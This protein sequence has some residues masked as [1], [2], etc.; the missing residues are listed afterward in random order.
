MR[1]PSAGRARGA[2]L[3]ARE[4]RAH[5]VRLQ[6]RAHSEDA[7]HARLERAA[8][9][10]ADLLHEPVRRGGVH[11]LG[12]E[13]RDELAL[14]LVGALLQAI[15]LAAGALAERAQSRLLAGVEPELRRFER[16]ARR[17]VRGLGLRGAREALAQ[18]PVPG[19]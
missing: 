9:Q 2:V 11:L 7:L 19:E 10:V 13:A 18:R 5:L 15:G 4:Q 1:A 8:A 12:R 6:D 16:A 14:Q 3:A 17:R